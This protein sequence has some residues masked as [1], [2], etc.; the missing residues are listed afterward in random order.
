[1]LNQKDTDIP[2]VILNHGY[3]LRSV[4][5]LDD[6]CSKDSWVSNNPAEDTTH[7]AGALADHT[8][9]EESTLIKFEVGTE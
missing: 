2:N 5:G 8:P 3:K 1:M 9:N 7:M 4:D 6:Y